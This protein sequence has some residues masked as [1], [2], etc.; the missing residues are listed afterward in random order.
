MRGF[1]LVRVV[2]LDCILEWLEKEWIKDVKEVVENY[3]EGN[4]RGLGK[5][6]IVIVEVIGK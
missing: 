6:D 1:L 3:E 5:V 2:W 4:C